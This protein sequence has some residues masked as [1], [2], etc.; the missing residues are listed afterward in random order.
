MAEL[1]NLHRDTEAQIL[2]AAEKEFLEKGFS[3]AKTTSIAEAAGVTHAMLHYYFRTKD[4]LFDKIVNDKIDQLK[5]IIFNAIGNSGL[6]LKE[7]IIQSVERHFDF[8]AA[9]PLLPRFIFNEVYSQPEKF[10]IIKNGM[11]PLV[12]SLLD[13][14]QG[15]INEEARCGRCRLVDA[16]MVFYDIISLNIFPFVAAPITNIVFGTTDKNLTAFLEM[17]KRENVETILRKL[18]IE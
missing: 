1:Q 16:R 17:R 12:G 2:Q 7:R 18:N 15:V 8:V 4:K 13:E 11:T 14:F 10:G 6:P 3:G 5:G 9:N